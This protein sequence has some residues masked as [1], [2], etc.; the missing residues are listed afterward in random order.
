MLAYPTECEKGKF[1]GIF[2]SVFNL[3]SVVGASV[4][5]GRNWHSRVCLTIPFLSLAVTDSVTF[6]ASFRQTK[7]RVL[8]SPPLATI[9]Q[10]DNLCS[11]LT[12]RSGQWH[13]RMSHSISVPHT[14][15]RLNG[16]DSRPAFSHHQIGFLALTSMGVAIPLM[17]A[18]PTKMV[19]NDGSKVTAPRHPSWRTEFW[20]LWV[21]LKTDPYIVLLFPMFFASN[22]FYTW[23]QY[24]F[25]P[26]LPLKGS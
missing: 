1:I 23:R 3:G 12:T 11:T 7:V 17:M 10:I 8:L 19:R 25:I 6:G 18:D 9:F 13:L 20:G 22:W 24:L 5:L 26:V 4:S 14:C 15:S 16:H 21:A 2:W